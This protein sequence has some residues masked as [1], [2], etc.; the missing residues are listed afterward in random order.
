VHFD[1]AA[2]AFTVLLEAAEKALAAQPPPAEGAEAK[3][4]FL[5]GGEA[6]TLAD[7]AFASLLARANW[8]AEPRALFSARPPVVA[9]WA[10]MHARPAFEAADVWTGLKPVAGLMMV[11][12]AALDASLFLWSS[13]EREWSA[14]VAPGA[15]K[16]WHTVADPVGDAARATGSAI[17]THIISPI[18]DSPQWK[19]MTLVV[20]T[21]VVPKF[22]AAAHSTGDF[23]DHHVV[24]PCKTAASATAE[25][26]K[27]A[28]EATAEAAQRAAAATA[29]VAKHAAE[30]TADAAHRAAEATKHAAEQAAEATKN[31]AERAKSGLSPKGGEGEAAP[32]APA[33][34][35][36]ADA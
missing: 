15:S 8:A 12:E 13:A 1:K 7:L 21:T 18:T 2:A 19:G 17:N 11:G 25:A 31:V 6:P 22:K 33:A 35:A 36:T 9:F 30:A 14:T 32:A 23:L 4:A 16:A 10:H 5:C 28:A 29:E 20:N 3:P 26:A 27:H 34:A 24:S